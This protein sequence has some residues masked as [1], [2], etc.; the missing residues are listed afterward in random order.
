MEMFG[1]EEAVQIEDNEIAFL[2]MQIEAERNNAK[3]AQMAR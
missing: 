1:L 3:M 2:K